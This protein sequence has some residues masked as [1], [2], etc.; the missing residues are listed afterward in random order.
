MVDAKNEE[1][2]T[3]DE[4]RSE[5]L[6]VFHGEAT[7]KE[8]KRAFETLYRA[9][10]Q[11]VFQ[12]VLMPVLHDETLAE[13]A[14]SITF[15]KVS[16]KL[17][18]F[19]ERGVSLSAWIARIAKNTAIDLLRRE[20]RIIG[21]HASFAS[22]V[23]TMVADLETPETRILSVDEK[24]AQRAQIEKTLAGLH[25]RYAETIRMRFLEEKSRAACAEALGV[26]L[27]TFDVIL[28]RSLRAFRKQWGASTQA[29]T[30]EQHG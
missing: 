24:R 2:T 4:G 10:A 15:R 26:K 1:G 23:T 29:S 16:D 7:E 21:R 5:F 8:K 14:L 30:S 20:N 28:L 12:R 3:S 11:I 13:E 25:E 27:A 18:T 17:C 9:N 6:R 19:E 22:A